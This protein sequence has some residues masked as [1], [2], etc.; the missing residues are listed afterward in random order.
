MTDNYVRL[1]WVE[2]KY[3]LKQLRIY[4]AKLSA[5][6]SL[7][8][9]RTVL[10]ITNKRPE[11]CQAS[12]IIYYA[13]HNAISEARSKVILNKSKDLLQAVEIKQNGR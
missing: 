10:E 7:Q 1:F 12:N 5:R 3:S 11:L 6:E 13:K 8:V 2:R 4:K 9:L